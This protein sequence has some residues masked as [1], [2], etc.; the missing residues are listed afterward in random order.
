MLR[1]E[2]EI[3]SAAFQDLKLFIDD[4]EQNK[5]IYSLEG[6]YTRKLSAAIVTANLFRR[7]FKTDNKELSK[8]YQKLFKQ[9]E[10]EASSISAKIKW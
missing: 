8:H 4:F 2:K 9:Y 1:P 7:I 10:T 5:N 6:G 3:K